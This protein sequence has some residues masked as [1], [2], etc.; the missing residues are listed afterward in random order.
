VINASRSAGGRS[1]APRRGGA[2]ECA[3]NALRV[4]IVFALFQFPYEVDRIPEEHVIKIFA[5]H[6]ADQPFL[7]LAADFLNV[8]RPIDIA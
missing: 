1:G 2:A 8:N 7:M 3:M 5:A 4:V 6:G